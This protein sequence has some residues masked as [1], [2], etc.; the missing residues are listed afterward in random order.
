MH[1]RSLIGYP[2]HHQTGRRTAVRGGTTTNRSRRALVHHLPTPSP[3]TALH[4]VVVAAVV[5]AN[6]GKRPHATTMGRSLGDVV[7]LGVPRKCLDLLFLFLFWLSVVYYLFIY[8]F[9]ALVG[10]LDE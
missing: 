5:V 9:I 4:P 1:V 6:P 2:H 10:W 8:L 3:P 7:H